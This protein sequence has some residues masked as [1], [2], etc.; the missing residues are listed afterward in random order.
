[1]PGMSVYSEIRM[2]LK[3]LSRPRGKLCSPWQTLFENP[4]LFPADSVPSVDVL[5][6][7]DDASLPI[8]N[9]DILKFLETT[10]FSNPE[11]ALNTAKIAAK[12]VGRL[13]PNSAHA[14]FVQA[15]KKVELLGNS[16]LPGWREA[17]VK[18]ILKIGDL[19][20]TVLTSSNHVALVRHIAHAVHL[21]VDSPKFYTELKG[22]QI[23]K[24]TRHCEA[25]L[26]SL[27]VFIFN[28]IN[29]DSKYADILEQLQ[30]GYTVFML[31]LQ[32]DHDFCGYRN[33]DES[34]GY[35]NGAAQHVD[36]CSSSLHK[37]HTH[38]L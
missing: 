8:T 11:D 1:M 17:T 4:A 19:E 2:F 6:V 31:S 23:F 21:L 35:R 32:S 27:L 37:G 5:D 16:R 34:S 38:S 20:T 33:V 14:T 29:L 36:I 3:K 22:L 12:A 25:C 28:N 24:G 15:T 30:V 7:L 9:A 18:L 10:V 13:K 26:A